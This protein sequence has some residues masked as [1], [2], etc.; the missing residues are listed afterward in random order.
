MQAD[1]L[2]SKFGSYRRKTEYRLNRAAG[3]NFQGKNQAFNGA[4]RAPLYRGI[5]A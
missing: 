4:A 3:E 5:T 1:D 2:Y